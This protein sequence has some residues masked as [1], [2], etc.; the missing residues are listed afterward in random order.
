MT[1]T[2][3]TDGVSWTTIG[4]TRSNVE[5]VGMPVTDAGFARRLERERNSLRSV[6]AEL[7]DALSDVVDDWRD[8]L[9]DPEA[10]SYRIARDLLAKAKEGQ[11]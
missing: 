11:P 10:D 4:A 7:L 3:E 2:P 5:P 9:T 1:D 8:G 6:N